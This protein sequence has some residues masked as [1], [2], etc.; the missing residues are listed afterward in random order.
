M[1]P[2]A[3]ADKLRR[4]DAARPSPPPPPPRR[5]ITT[6]QI[7]R[8]SEYRA[9]GLSWLR[10]GR[11]L[12]VCPQRLRETAQWSGERSPIGADPARS[13]PEPRSWLQTGKER[14]ETAMP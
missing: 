6:A 8:A 5:P 4:F 9:L 1:T 13:T 3:L 2:K 10:C 14:R 7:E 12:R 11:L